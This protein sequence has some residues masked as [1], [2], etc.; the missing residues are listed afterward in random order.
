LQPDGFVEVRRA[1]RTGCHA[2]RSIA[3]RP[4]APLVAVA[5]SA[6][7]AAVHV[8][9]AIG[10]RAGLGN[11]AD[12]ADEA[13]ATGWFAAYNASVSVLAV[14]GAGIAVVLL[15]RPAARRWARWPTAIGGCLL[16]ARGGLGTLL[17]VDAV[18]GGIEDAPPLVLLA[19]EPAF[20]VGGL[21][22]VALARS[23]PH[24][25]R[26]DPAVEASTQLR[27]ERCS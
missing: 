23:A 10:G 1:L 21:A 20:L 16:L 11:E 17:L 3:D 27:A 5:W 19:I 8:Y 4:V 14:L 6:L 24:A 9:R 13:L 12:A 25:G 15:R 22:Y 26:R 18:D 2:V 7:F